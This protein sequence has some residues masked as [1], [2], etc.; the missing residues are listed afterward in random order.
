[1]VISDAIGW[2]HD[3]P[4]HPAEEIAMNA[5]KIHQNE[6]SATPSTA[7]PLPLSPPANSSRDKKA[8]IGVVGLGNM[9]SA[10]AATLLSNGHTVVA[11]DRNPQRTEALRWEGAQGAA[12]LTDLSRCDIV[13]SSLPDD[14]ALESVVLS[15]GGLLDVLKFGALHI[16]TSTVSAELSRRLEQHHTEARQSFVAATLLGNPDLAK[17]QRIFVM[18]AGTPADV[19]RAKPLLEQLGQRLFDMGEDPG[20]ANVMKL[21]CNVLTATTL[22][23]MGEVLTLLTKAGIDP[24]RGFEV[25]TGSLFDGRVHKAYGGKIVDKRFKPAGMT[26]PLAVKDL[27]LALAEAE[28]QVVPMPMASLVHDRLVALVAAGWGELDWSALG[29]LAA[30]DAGLKDAVGAQ[31]P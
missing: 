29:A 7:T 31:A 14:A 17:M 22:Q 2:V 25:F 19:Q 3:T 6:S 4:R 24:H 5:S 18:A 28:Q 8:R 27:R 16:S 1:V 20:A 21:A 23:S 10:L 9:G 12:S 15:P 26:A 13:I 30:R 11:Y